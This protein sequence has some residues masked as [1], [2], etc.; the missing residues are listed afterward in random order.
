[1]RKLILILSIL[2]ITFPIYSGYEKTTHRVSDQIIFMNETYAKARDYYLH[3]NYSKALPLLFDIINKYPDKILTI[4][5]YALQYRY[6]AGPGA[7]DMIGRIYLKTGKIKEAMECFDQ[8]Y[9][10]YPDDNFIGAFT[11]LATLNYGGIAGAEALCCEMWILSGNFQGY[12]KYLAGNKPDYNLSIIISRELIEKYNGVTRRC[13]GDCENY[14]ETAADN[15]VFCLLAE[16]A[17]IRKTEG[18]IRWT[19][20]HTKN[21]PLQA[22]LLLELGNI[23]HEKKDDNKAIKTF[24][25]VVDK[26]GDTYYYYTADNLARF[27]PIEAF[28]RILAILTAEKRSDDIEKL[29]GDIA[30]VYYEFEQSIEKVKKRRK[31]YSGITKEHLNRA[32]EENIYKYIDLN[33]GEKKDIQ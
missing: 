19:I 10:K 8:M 14:E 22:S 21:R 27:Y 13:Y 30:L 23:C 9:K 6:K 7:L 24:M 26:Y 4:R 25:E 33:V 28:G 15:I 17:D 12:E 20:N 3:D 1:L 32:M 29:K 5:V 11:S 16:K 2:L 18:E 31:D